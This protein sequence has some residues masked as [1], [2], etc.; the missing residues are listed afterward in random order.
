MPI[1]KEEFEGVLKHM[2]ISFRKHKISEEL[3]KEIMDI[4]WTFYDDIV[5]IK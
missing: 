5:T 3:I 1:R 4:L 2:G